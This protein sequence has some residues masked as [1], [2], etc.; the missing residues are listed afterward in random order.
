MVVVEDVAEAAV[1]IFE[2]DSGPHYSTLSLAVVG[3]VRQLAAELAAS[4]HCRCR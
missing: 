1:V 3:V 4:D 2:C